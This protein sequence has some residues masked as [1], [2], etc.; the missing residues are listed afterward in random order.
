MA[1]SET[2]QNETKQVEAKQQGRA[3][4]EEEGQAVPSFE[5][6]EP[7]PA[8]GSLSPVGATVTAIEVFADED[9]E[10]PDAGELSITA[11][12]DYDADEVE[13]FE[14]EQVTS[15]QAAGGPGGAVVA[16]NGNSYVFSASQLGV[17]ARL[18]TTAG[19]AAS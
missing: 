11:D 7:K 13:P 2:K 3:P 19:A 16:I 17:L 5:E 18:V 15:L 14:G 1:G 4:K 6:L 12:V 8:P 10:L 9:G